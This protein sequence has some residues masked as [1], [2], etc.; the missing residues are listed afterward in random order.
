MAAAIEV[1]SCIG[2]GL[3]AGQILVVTNTD[4]NFGKFAE[5]LEGLF[6]SS[7]GHLLCIT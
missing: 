2:R 5:S 3:L 6:F 4:S 7:L 1:L